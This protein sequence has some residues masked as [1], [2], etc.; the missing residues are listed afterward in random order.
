MEP[1]TVTS[2]QVA[3]S[4]PVG[5]VQPGGVRKTGRWLRTFLVGV[6]VLTSVT[7]EA[8]SSSSSN[9]AS[10]GGAVS[11]Q[12]AAVL[13]AVQILASDTGAAN[14]YRGGSYC[15]R[16][17]GGLTS[18]RESAAFNCKFLTVSD[19]LHLLVA[20][21]YFP[22]VQAEQTPVE[23]AVLGLGQAAV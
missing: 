4:H 18:S 20:S 19:Y 13:G 1:P 11:G 7:G 3:V 2:G 16:A 23:P 14:A 5:R 6:V 12:T 10:T 15:S 22:V 9:G 8:N 17:S 21:K